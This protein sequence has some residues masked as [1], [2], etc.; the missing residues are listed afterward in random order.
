[1]NTLPLEIDE[2]T[3]SLL[4]I[5]ANRWG[6]TVAEL[7][8]QF[9]HQGLGLSSQKL[10]IHPDLDS[11]AGTWTAAQERE[12]LEAVAPFSKIDKEIWE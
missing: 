11:L 9:I 6:M 4:T 5:Q 12:F 7:A 1:M 2:Q 3:T 10:R 8:L